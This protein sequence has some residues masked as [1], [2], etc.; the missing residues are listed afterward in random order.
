MLSIILHVTFRWIPR[1]N[2]LQHCTCL[3][4]MMS[5][6]VMMH[7]RNN[8]FYFVIHQNYAWH[9][10]AIF[11]AKP[12]VQ[13]GCIHIILYI[14]DRVFSYDIVYAFDMYSFLMQ[15][16]PPTLVCSV[17]S[18]HI[19][20][21]KILSGIKTN[22]HFW[23]VWNAMSISHTPTSVCSI[24]GWHIK[25]GKI[26]VGIK[27]ST[28]FWH[29]RNAMSISHTVGDYGDVYS[30]H[31]HLNPFSYL[32]YPQQPPPWI[33]PSN[34]QILRGP[35]LNFWIQLVVEVFGMYIW[36][37]A[38]TLKFCFDVWDP[39]VKWSLTDALSKMVDDWTFLS[40]TWSYK[41]IGGCIL[42][43][44]M[45]LDGMF[46]IQAIWFDICPSKAF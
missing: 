24:E 23:H 43:L 1:Q 34:G 5:I 46:T 8:Y 10:H 32:L 20:K 41:S 13:L 22:I 25:Q 30:F 11:F 3:N 2:E 36:L 45:L 21:G 28:Y 16:F 42:L 18:W 12:I 44:V 17:D 14:F 33:W 15:N 4:V 19:N 38:T 6:H 29:V 7:E 31:L 26:L 40:F 27:T 37:L 35:F 39:K 9:I